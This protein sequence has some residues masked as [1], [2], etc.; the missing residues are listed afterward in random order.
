MRKRAL[1]LVLLSRLADELRRVAMVDVEAESSQ[2]EAS[3]QLQWRLVG[4]HEVHYESHAERGQHG[5]ADVRERSAKPSHEA[6]P[7]SLVEGAAD[8]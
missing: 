1:L 6:V 4:L 5:V 7:S 3:H 8:A 2:H